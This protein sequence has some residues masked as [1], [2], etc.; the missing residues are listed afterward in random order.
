MRGHREP[1]VINGAHGEGGGALLRTALAMSAL[2]QQPVR[3]HGIRGALR[4]PGLNSEDLTVLAAL[5]VSCRADVKGDDLESK[6]L[7]FEPTTTPKALDTK[8]DVGVFEKGAV[9]GGGPVILE[10]L[11]PVLI[12]SGS[13]SH[14][15]VLAET[16][17]QNTLGYDAFERVSLA[18]H[19]AQGVYAFPT[20]SWAAFGS[21]A[22]GEMSLEIEP[23]APL[24]LQWRERGELLG[25][26]GQVSYADVSPDIAERGVK[27]IRS[28]FEARG[29]ECEVE[30]VPFRSRG[31]GVSVTVWAEFESGTGSGTMNGQRG[32]KMEAVVDSAFRS[33]DEWFNSDATVDSFLADQL[34]LIAAQGE[35]KTV[36]TTPRVT[37][38]LVTMSWVIK[39]FMPVHITIKGE[40][41]YPG[42][43]TIER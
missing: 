37:R 16:H 12:R 25:C 34:L 32:V 8:L 23:S 3:L 31:S 43:V 4:K 30:A 1:I 18:A 19:R 22:K 26:Y 20:V 29:R 24:G 21:G 2:T 39:Q 33:F 6:E 9:P 15:T 10:S 35:Q 28:T 7:L 11:L 41:G 36:F 40:E 38:R 5:A 17:G 27:H 42:T 14:L 13:Y